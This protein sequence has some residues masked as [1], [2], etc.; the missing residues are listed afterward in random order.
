MLYRA[1]VP[2]YAAANRAAA[3]IGRSTLGTFHQRQGEQRLLREAGPVAAGWG[4]TFGEQ[5]RQQWSGTVSPSL[6]GSLQGF[7]VGHDLFAIEANS[8]YRQHAGV[9]VGRA[10]S[11]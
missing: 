11:S 8:G 4:Q 1:E 9:Y 7:E 10:A 5:V 6:K 3:L 2:L